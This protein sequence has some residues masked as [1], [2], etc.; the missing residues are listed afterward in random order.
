ML[1]K[2][3]HSIMRD[4]SESGVNIYSFW[5]TSAILRSR[6]AEPET[7]KF[8]IAVFAFSNVVAANDDI[9]TADDTGL[10]TSRSTTDESE[11]R[12]CGDSKNRI[13]CARCRKQFVPVQSGLH[14]ELM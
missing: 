5:P 1:T 14:V 3:F 10:T 7:E 11:V 2:V 9:T 6:A 8:V 12:R 13:V 4:N